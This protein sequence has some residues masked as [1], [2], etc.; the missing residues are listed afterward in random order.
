MKKIY[1][2]KINF[3]REYEVDTEILFKL[4]LDNLSKNGDFSNGIN[5][6]FVCEYH[7]DPY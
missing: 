3:I 4:L 5:N 7:K 6:T 2:K 1:K